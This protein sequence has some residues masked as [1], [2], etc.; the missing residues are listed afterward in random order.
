MRERSIKSVI[1]MNSRVFIF[2]A[3]LWQI[4]RTLS[5]TLKIFNS[6][7]WHYWLNRHEFG[8]TPGVGDG[9]GGLVCCSPWGHKELDTA[10]WLNWTE[11]M[12]KKKREIR[13]ENN[14][15]C[16]IYGISWNNDFFEDWKIS[17]KATIGER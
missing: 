15:T 8:W 2:F 9:Q 14:V 4:I 3:T 12:W 10:E 5:G 16:S 7:M 1:F 6:C 17:K 13:K 11:L